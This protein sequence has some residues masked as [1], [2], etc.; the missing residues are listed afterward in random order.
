[1]NHHTHPDTFLGLGRYLT[2]A[3]KAK[4]V[5]PDVLK[6]LAMARK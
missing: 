3:P 2:Q 4:Q 1:M 5:P 6:A